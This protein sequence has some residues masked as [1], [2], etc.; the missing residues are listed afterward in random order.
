MGD[1]M[2]IACIIARTHICMFTVCGPFY[3]DFVYNMY[4]SKLC[5]IYGKK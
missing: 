1:D 4:M 3:T 2:S 5:F